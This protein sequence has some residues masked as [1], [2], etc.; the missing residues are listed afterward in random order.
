LALTAASMTP[1]FAR[2]S[3]EKVLGDALAQGLLGE[4]RGRETG[5]RLF[6]E[7]VVVG[8]ALL[9]EGEIDQAAVE[10]MD[11]VAGLSD[12]GLHDL[13]VSFERAEH[14]VDEFGPLQVGERDLEVGGVE[15]GELNV[16]LRDE[17]HAALGVVA[18]PAQEVALADQRS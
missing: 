8:E 18:E 10:M 3:N 13:P 2:I 12:G 15:V 1:K 16:D 17:E 14:G 11:V 5:G 9:P 4:K 6:E 7:L